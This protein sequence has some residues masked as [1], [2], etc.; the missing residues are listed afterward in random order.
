[1]K[2]VTTLAIAGAL[3]GTVLV[4]SASA[5]GNG[6]VILRADL[7]GAEEVPPVETE[8]SGSAKFRINPNSDEIV[9][10]LKV[11]DGVGLLGVAGAHVHCG[12][13][14]QNGPVAAFL[15][16]PI[17]GGIDGMLKVKGTITDV[18]VIPTACGSDVDDLVA[19]MQAGNTYVNVHSSGNPAG[20]VRGQIG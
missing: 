9:F 14:G 20:E 15:A 12:S 18:D 8:T 3:L 7:T 16:T 13:A 10:Q 6:A 19:A 1:M 17:A 5:G 11:K 2:F 4:S